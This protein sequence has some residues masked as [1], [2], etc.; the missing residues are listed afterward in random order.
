MLH[1][2]R[3]AVDLLDASISVILLAQS[4]LIIHEQFLNMPLLLSKGEEIGLV[5]QKENQLVIKFFTRLLERMLFREPGRCG[6]VVSASA[7]QAGGLWLKSGCWNTHVGKQPA[8]MLAIYTSRGVT[9]EVNLRERIS[10]TPLQSSNKAEPTLALKPRGDL[11]RSLKQGY[12]WPQKWTC[13]QQKF[14]RKKKE[15]YSGWS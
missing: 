2:I 1:G 5:S 6:R 13:V 8:A 14:K 7:C 9:P 12:Q 3:A 11:T 10:H 4:K 15:C